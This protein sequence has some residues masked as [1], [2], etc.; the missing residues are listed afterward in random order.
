[1][2]RSQTN[3]PWDSWQKPYTDR[4]PPVWFHDIFHKDGTPYRQEEVDFIR[5]MTG[6][7]SKEQEGKERGLSRGTAARRAPGDAS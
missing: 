7:R 5:Q 3:L 4:E 2:A 6:L 1:M